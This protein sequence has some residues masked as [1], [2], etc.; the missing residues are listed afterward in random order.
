MTENPSKASHMLVILISATISQVEQFG[1]LRLENVFRLDLP[2]C[3]VTLLSNQTGKWLEESSLC[4][5]H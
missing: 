2:A 4:E 1:S 5:W 3:H